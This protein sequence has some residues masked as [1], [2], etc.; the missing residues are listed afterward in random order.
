MKQYRNYLF[1]ILSFLSFLPLKAQVIETGDTIELDSPVTWS[2]SYI[3]TDLITLNAGFSFDASTGIT[4]QAGMES[5]V[6]PDGEYSDMLVGFVNDT[7]SGA[8]APPGSIP[9]NLSV[10]AI[11]GLQYVVPLE[12]PQGMG[13]VKPNLSIVYN[14]AKGMGVL[15]TGWNLTG[16][17]AITRTIKTYYFDD[18]NEAITFTSDDAYSIDGQRLV[19]ESDGGSIYYKEMDDF[20]TITKS[21]SGFTMETKDGTVMTYGVGD[22]KLFVPGSSSIVMSWLIKSI[23][24][25]RG[26][27]VVYTYD[28]TDD[29]QVKVTS[30]SYGNSSADAFTI[31]FTY[32]TKSATDQSHY[33]IGGYKF[34]NDLLLTD[35]SC[36]DGTQYVISSSGISLK[37]DD[38]LQ[39]KQTTFTKVSNTNALT[40]SEDYTLPNNPDGS[41]QYTVDIDGDGV[42]E[43]LQLNPS[44]RTYQVGHV[45][46]N[47]LSYDDA[48]SLPA[49]NINVY[50]R[51]GSL[52]A[53]N[54]YLVTDFN[55][56]GLADI[57][58]FD[59]DGYFYYRD[60]VNG[61][62]NLL[63]SKTG[64]DDSCYVYIGDFNG[65]GS[66][67]LLSIRTDGTTEL[68][69]DDGGVVYHQARISSLGA[70]VG[71]G[72]YNNNARTDIVTY[73]YST[74]QIYIKEMKKG[75]DGSYSLATKSNY[76]FADL[77]S[78]KQGDFNGD[79]L[80]DLLVFS[81]ENESWTVLISDGDFGFVEQ[82][83][84]LE[85][86]PRDRDYLNLYT[87]S[88]LENG[89]DLI[90]QQYLIADINNDGKSD[91]IH[92]E[93]TSG[94]DVSSLVPWSYY[95]NDEEIVASD[96]WEY[97]V[98]IDLHTF[99]SSGSS[100][101]QYTYPG[102][103]FRF[104]ADA[105]KIP[106]LRPYGYTNVLGDYY[107]NQILGVDSF[108]SFGDIDSDGIPDLIYNNQYGNS[109]GNS[110]YDEDI[111]V[112]NFSST[113]HP[114]WITTIKEGN[115]LKSTISY[116]QLTANEDIPF[117]DNLPTDVNKVYSHNWGVT[118][119]LQKD[120]SSNIVR[121]QEYTYGYGLMHKY[122]G[123]LGFM[124]SQNEE[125]V[126]GTKVINYSYST[127]NLSYF[128]P[129]QSVTL[130]YSNG[131]LMSQ[132][133]TTGNFATRLTDKKVFFEYLEF[134]TN[135]DNVTG[136][137][138]TKEYNYNT[139]LGSTQS[140]YGNL[141]TETINYDDDGSIVTTYSNYTELGM[142]GSITST[143]AQ[144]TSFSGIKS[145][146]YDTYGNIL[147]KTDYNKGITKTYTYN[148]DDHT[149][150]VSIT[151]TGIGSY[152]TLKEYSYDE[153]GRFVTEEKTTFG[154]GVS[155]VK[156]FTYDSDG[157]LLS[158]IDE[159]GLTTTYQYDSYGTIIMKTSPNGRRTA[160]TYGYSND[161]GYSYNSVQDETGN[162]STTYYDIFNR[163]V[164]TLD[165][166]YG[167]TEV[168]NI[169]TYN[170]N[171]T[172]AQEESSIDGITS[173]TY[174]NGGFI[175]KIVGK[176]QTINYTY[177]GS[178]TK[179]TTGGRTSS[180]TFN[181]F[182]DLIE[183]S[184]YAGAITYAYHP[185]GQVE[186]IA[187]GGL[188]TEIEYDDITGEQK[189]L[190]D[191][192]AG[193]NT[194]NYDNNQLT[195][196][197]DGND[198][199][200]SFEYDAQNRIIKKTMGDR[201]IEYFYDPDDTHF[202]YLYKISDSESDIEIN[203]AYDDLG[204]LLS[205]TETIDGIDYTFSYQYDAAGR[206]IKI[207]YPDNYS[208][209]QEF[210]G[211]Y[212]TRISDSRGN[213]LFD[214][215]VYNA[216]G[217]VTEYNEGNGNTINST[218]DTY[219]FLS[220]LAVGTSAN[221]INYGYTFDHSTTSLSQRS[222]S[223]GDVLTTESFTYDNLNRLTAWNPVY[224]DE[225]DSTYSA[226]F[227]MS[228]QN[229][230]NII[231][232]SDLGYYSYD[233][234]HP[235]AVDGVYA[236]SGTS[237]DS[238][239]NN[240]D[241][242]SF[243]KAE[244]LTI[245]N[246][247]GDTTDRYQITYGPDDQRRKTDYNGFTTLYIG[248]YELR[249]DG[250]ALHYVST[251]NGINGCYVT[252]SVGE[253]EFYYLER[254]YL[255][256]LI[257]VYKEDASLY[258]EFN[259]DPWG[260]RRDAANWTQFASA[261]EDL[262][263]RGYTGHEHIVGFGLIN[264]NGRIYDSRL[265]RMLSPDN[266]VQKPDLT[267]NLNR[268]GYCLNNPMLYT[269]PTGDFFWLPIIIGAALYATANTVI[270]YN[271]GD[272][273]DIWD[274]LG[275]FAQGAVTGAV[276]G[277][278]WSIGIAGVASGSLAAQIGGG[279]ILAGKGINAISTIASAASDVENAGKILMGR[280]YT[281]KNLD[282]DFLSPIIQGVSRYT[283]EGFQTWVGYNY[284][285]FRNTAGKVD[286]VDYL[287]GAT[288][289]TNE[290][291]GK[292]NGVTMGNYININIKD[293]V[294][295]DFTSYALTAHEGLYM[296]EYG[297][298]VQGQH[299]GPFFLPYIGIQSLL[300]ANKHDGKHKSQ[301]YE[302]E[303]SAYARKYFSEYYGENVWTST[304]EKRHPTNGF[305]GY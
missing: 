169:Y 286:R 115:G 60:I 220:H 181:A 4:F 173:Y 206:T 178:T 69:F 139:Y 11:G 67:N 277:A 253:G 21:S 129:L 207:T 188:S 218:Y 162:V 56:D 243:G 99:V 130:S 131:Q 77:K 85:G 189:A 285:Q 119:I 267:Q 284:T 61:T 163:K 226:S 258:K 270:H 149:N 151:E 100:F 132:V 140:D 51:S 301:W 125:E 106:R 175:G 252:D 83:I 134:Q 233:A 46:D 271:N 68:D 1:L 217:Q 49:A 190:I 76:P 62:D 246:A 203:Y 54:P 276:A 155:Y 111:F 58:Y 176:G 251:P 268:Y 34:V 105:P 159:N 266:Y 75:T 295:G 195:S 26:N 116:S 184:D 19:L 274:A 84:E 293:K 170:D 216:R 86:D 186:T 235:H 166:P 200:T 80:S 59:E 47:T 257:A 102:G 124:S 42:N 290:K 5:P 303:A 194:Y 245:L 10:S 288:F 29:G 143:R 291:A 52:V 229:N 91:I 167:G 283:W 240:I 225:N 118:N 90:K 50:Y 201:V 292:N 87:Y 141:E 269:D 121:D 128:K 22:A 196:Q 37:K 193:T 7:V 79:G 299:Y 260:R 209:S 32:S 237:I 82:S 164:K 199:T 278:T 39:Y 36:S 44:Y 13:G 204:Q 6:I 145:L 215:F 171:G 81:S 72:N 300:S 137:T 88:P 272:I 133:T 205:Q 221:R 108:W 57:G 96:E 236:L 138:I 65:D 172:L 97:Y 179:V 212:L 154:D 20:S 158:S 262:F 282:G 2:A 249:S 238:R 168:S 223:F 192:D 123:F 103:E 247:S 70:I 224:T 275:Y 157:N 197:V 43:Y 265:A 127:S 101:T 107:F 136:F 66:P 16:L 281:D 146:T 74:D 148:E 250:T 208:V 114:G 182:G 25:I 40:I 202:G 112:C 135:L 8:S 165:L 12:F 63:E 219:G 53:G 98:K 259:Y 89:G 264:M 117:N 73:D 122:R 9:A 142:P 287:G 177:S 144:G 64:V 294:E 304:I 174:K 147:T 228:F 93:R 45:V 120:E 35:V 23:V 180:K 27:K 15:G 30:I 213:T 31:D 185:S 302:R 38:V 254:D 92:I 104:A 230:G 48:I 232:K 3:A 33:Y 210:D 296:H 289:A 18:E 126:T 234:N 298:T 214:G 231:Q 41:D 94:T 297:H 305:L 156:T 222:R 255:G 24:D 242:T 109:N 161:E 241:Y 273:H 183:A 227:S 256:S 279:A 150:V 280:A 28:N 239:Q 71:M 14:N 17:S 153:T 244:L 113:P 191:P 152:S 198:I 78:F 95:E 55:R 110:E 263:T 248:S 261:E 187:F 211:D 160:I